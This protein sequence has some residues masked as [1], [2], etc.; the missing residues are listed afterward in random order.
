MEQEKTRYAGLIYWLKDYGKWMYGC[1][2]YGNGMTY[3][4]LIDEDGG[5]AYEVVVE[6]HLN[7]GDKITLHNRCVESYHRGRYVG[8][9]IE[10]L[11]DA[12]LHVTYAEP[13]SSTLHQ[14][15]IPLDS[16]CWIDGYNKD[17]NWT[18]ERDKEILLGKEI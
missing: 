7:N 5:D 12:M 18:E 17:I 2:T 4:K 16:I 13:H 15:H 10:I 11:D 14:C 1:A 6:L 8:D 3:D 9:C